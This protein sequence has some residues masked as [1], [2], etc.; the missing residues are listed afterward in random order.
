M[1]VNVVR[2]KSMSLHAR[3]FPK[4]PF[5]VTSDNRLSSFILKY[6]AMISGLSCGFNLRGSK[7]AESQANLDC[8]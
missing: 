2:T 7:L 8:R 1:Q 5:F 3:T 6:L 4:T